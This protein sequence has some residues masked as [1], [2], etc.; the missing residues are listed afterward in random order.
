M[1]THKNSFF[2]HLVPGTKKPCDDATQNLINKKALK[3]DGDKIITE[4][5]VTA[6]YVL[7]KI[8]PIAKQRMFV[9]IDTRMPKEMDV[10]MNSGVCKLIEKTIWKSISVS[11]LFISETEEEAKNN[12]I[13]SVVK[14]GFE[15]QMLVDYLYLPT[16]LSHPFSGISVDT[17][18]GRIRESKKLAVACFTDGNI[19]NCCVY[20]MHY[21]FP[22]LKTLG[23]ISLL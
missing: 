2:A 18:A 22:R 8:I 1:I 15:G 14:K 5:K 10:L 11:I 21:L 19:S 9:V 20:A 12:P 6:I 13:F 16:N 17:H 23:S 3:R 7:K 4:N